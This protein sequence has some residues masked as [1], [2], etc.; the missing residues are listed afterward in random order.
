M[1]ARSGVRRLS[2]FIASVWLLLWG[3]AY[4]FDAPP[5]NWSGYFLFGIGPVALLIG[6]PWGIWWVSAGFRPDRSQ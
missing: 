2:V 3:L 4:A 6:V 5:F 1:A